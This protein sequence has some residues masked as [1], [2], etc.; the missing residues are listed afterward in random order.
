MPRSAHSRATTHYMQLFLARGSRWP[1]RTWGSPD[2]CRS[3][4]VG[5]CWHNARSVVAIEPDRL[6]YVE[7]AVDRNGWEPHAWA[8]DKETGAVEE[9]T[10]S[11]EEATRYRG[12]VL[13]LAKVDLWLGPERRT[14]WNAPAGS[15]VWI[16]LYEFY[17]GRMKAAELAR[18]LKQ[19]TGPS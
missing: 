10:S 16:A 19:L 1:I 2:T 15:A 18:T 7:G 4:P 9:V 11:Y 6:S 17:E 12:L 8:V 5:L 3:G 13:D 14:R